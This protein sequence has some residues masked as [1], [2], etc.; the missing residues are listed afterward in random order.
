MEANYK[1]IPS[2][3]DLDSGQSGDLFMKS[4]NMKRKDCCFL[5]LLLTKEKGIFV[6]DQVQMNLKSVDGPGD[7]F[8]FAKDTLD[9]TV[10]F[11]SAD[12]INEAEP[13]QQ[14]SEFVLIS[15]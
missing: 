10:M 12:G 5:G 13:L 4:R 7:L 6:G 15:L 14:M 3:P 8:L 11:N 1:T 9:P 2:E